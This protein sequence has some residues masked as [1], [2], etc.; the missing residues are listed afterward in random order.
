MREA[1]APYYDELS[2]DGM[3]ALTAP[4]APFDAAML[5]VVLAIKPGVVS[6]HFGLPEAAMLDTLRAAGILILCSATTVAEARALEAAGVD[7]IIAQGFEAGGHRGTFTEPHEAGTIG[8][9]ALVPQ[10]VDAVSVPVIAAGGIADGRGIAAAFALGAS[11]VQPGT[12]FLSCPEAGTQ[13]LYRQALAEARDDAT[14]LTRAFS[15]R[16]ARALR[17]RFVDEMAPLEGEAAPFPLQRSLTGPLAAAAQAE[18]SADF[19]TLW[20]GQAAALNR[21]LPA[22]EL[23]ELLVREARAILHH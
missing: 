10:V 13:P 11:G 5:E 21:A 12:A 14:R 15:G 3:P 2:L 6:F 18:G 8:T 4:M 20:S 17:N 19:S 7:A 1:L 16:P 22:A 9:F 23:V